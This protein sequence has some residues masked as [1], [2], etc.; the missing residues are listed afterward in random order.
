MKAF[1]L[2]KL[3]FTGLESQHGITIFLKSHLKTTEFRSFKTNTI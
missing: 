3:H 1:P 2:I